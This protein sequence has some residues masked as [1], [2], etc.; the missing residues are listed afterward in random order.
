MIVLAEGFLVVGIL[1]GGILCWLGYRVYRMPDR[2]GRP[3]FV[4]FAV[5]LGTGC[6]VTGLLGFLPSA[7]SID[8]SGPIW[9]QIPMWFWV[10]ATFPWFV[11]A[12]QYTG[13]RRKVDRRTGLVLSLPYTFIFLQF[14]LS[15]INA[16]NTVLSALG[17]V[18]FIY[19]V[20]LVAGGTYLLFQTVRSAGHLSLGQGIAVSLAPIAPLAIWNAMSMPTEMTVTT[21]TGIFAAGAGFSA[22][23]LGTALHWYDLFESTPS[24]D[25]LGKRALLGETDDLMFVVDDDERV[26]RINERAVDTLGVQRSDLLGTT[27]SAVLDHDTGELQTADTVT[28]QTTQG[29]RQYDLQESVVTDH[30]G[31]DIGAVLSLRDVTERELREQRLTVL[32]RVLRHNLRNQADVVRGHAESLETDSDQVDTIINAAD[33][34]ADL[35]QQARRIDQCVSESTEDT[36][37]DL[38]TVVDRVLDMVGAEDAD[39]SVS[40]DVPASA[41]I[42]TS[43]MALVSSLESALEN[44]ITYADSTV[45]VTVEERPDAVVLYVADDGPGVP[46][47][48]LDSLDT[49]TETALQHSTGL[50]LWQLKWGVMTLNGELSFDTEDGTT[51]EIVVPDREGGGATAA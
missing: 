13:T 17:S 7:I 31:N 6:L 42:V 14:A 44:A 5:V 9:P 29:I 20:S 45:S 32:N 26:I 41:R 50:G 19:T 47:W 11:F 15:P 4:G 37:V 34:I 3:P 49:A 40:V 33:A 16:G 21:R 46:E 36:V 2:L 23:A 39:V 28:I 25:T 12:V 18:T 10:F 38:Q 30:Y 48:E 43:E 1:A 8:V 27:L 51:V 35:G 22:L 24:I